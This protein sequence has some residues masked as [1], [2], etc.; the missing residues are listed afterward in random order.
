MTNFI[1]DLD[2]TLYS[3][4]DVDETSYSKFYNSFKRKPFLNKLLGT[5]K[6]NKYIFSNGNKE[7]VDQVIKK[8]RMKSVF[9][10]T[11]NSDEYKNSKPYLDA[12][13]Y[14]IKKFKFDFNKPTYFF[15]DTLENLKTAKKFGW[16][17]ILISDN[18]DKK[19][20]YVDYIF[21]NIEEALIFLST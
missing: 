18:F 9:K 7:H 15:E 13:K 3:T 2:Y 6:G 20:N 4:N 21:P 5:L 12:Y 1:F 19:Y 17:T 8:M 14:V 11:A 10:G 16:I